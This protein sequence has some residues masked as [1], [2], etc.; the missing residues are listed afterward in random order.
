MGAA[1]ITGAAGGIGGAIARA[2]ADAG[3]DVALLD[4]VRP[5]PLGD[6]EGLALAVDLTDPD[7]VG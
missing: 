1:A 5:Q 2:L 4:R 3:Y 7:A 6:G